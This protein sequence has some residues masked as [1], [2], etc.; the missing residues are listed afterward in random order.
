M[1]PAV[2]GSAGAAA[3]AAVLVAGQSAAGRWRRLAFPAL[4]DSRRRVAIAGVVTCAFA[5]GVLGPSGTVVLIAVVSL[6]AV[7]MQRARR[8]ALLD[9]TRVALVD[10][11]RAMAAELRAGR[12]LADAFTSAAS[13]APVQ[14]VQALRPAVA[15]CRRGDAADVAEVLRA[16]ARAP[17]CS[18]LRSVAACWQVATSSGSTLAPAIDRVGDALQDDID[19]RR[20]VR[21]LLAGP[22]ATMRLLAVLPVVG[23]LLG[24]AIGA[25]PWSFLLRSPPGWGCLIGALLF[26]GAG[27]AWSRRIA[28]RA[29]RLGADV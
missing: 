26:D 3:A 21:S 29:T 22:R 14:V 19:L 8:A 20:D 15:A 24:S 17:G 4:R 28:A 18:A 11:C 23:L 12:P 9:E 27:I 13:D 16:A 6:G 1:N 10:L 2:V 7:V 25:R 5:V